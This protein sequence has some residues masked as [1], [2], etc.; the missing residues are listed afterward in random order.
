MSKLQRSRVSQDASS[1]LL[2]NVREE[3]SNLSFPP[4]NVM[5]CSGASIFRTQAARDVGCL[6]DVDPSVTLW[7]C[8]PDVLTHRGR[9]HVPDFAVH[10]ASSSTLIDVVSPMRR[11]PPAWARMAAEKLGFAYEILREAD[12]CGDVRLENAR[13]LLQYAHYRATLGDRVRIL[14]LIEEHGSQPLSACLLMVRNSHDAIGVVAALTLRRFIEMDLD[15][16]RIGPHT[17]VSAFKG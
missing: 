1:A 11:P 6:L 9:H 7:Q 3:A 4:K 10:R 17:R 5:R 12:L 16:A 13:D 15:E 14:G 2:A 8:L